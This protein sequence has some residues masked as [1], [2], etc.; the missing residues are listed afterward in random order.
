MKIEIKRKLENKVFS[1]RFTR[2]LAH[3]DVDA[4]KEEELEN[5]FGPVSLDTGGVTEAAMKIEAGKIVFDETEGAVKNIRFN[6]RGILI[7]LIK[8]ATFEYTC[9][10]KNETPVIGFTALQTA[11]AKCKAYEAKISE[12]VKKAVVEWRK[13]MTSFEEEVVAPIEED[14]TPV[15]E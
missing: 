11:E 4:A 12:E 14:L 6:A 8:D 10:A 2:V 13:Q 15:V 1:T 5:D 9:D 7:Q 3:D